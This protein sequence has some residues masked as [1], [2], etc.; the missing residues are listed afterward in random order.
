MD[1]FM[2][3]LVDSD[4]NLGEEVRLGRFVEVHDDVGKEARSARS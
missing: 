3:L 2:E 1:I 4:A